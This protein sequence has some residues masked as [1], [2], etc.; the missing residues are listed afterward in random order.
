MQTPAQPNIIAQ[1]LPMVIIFGI[2][3][4]LVIR[5]ERKKQKDHQLLLAGIKKNDEVVTASGI[6]GTVVIVKD[7]TVVLRLDENCRVEFDKEAVLTIVKK[8]E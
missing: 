6:H 3:Y 2:F 8:A 7:K 4:F 1:L 5:P